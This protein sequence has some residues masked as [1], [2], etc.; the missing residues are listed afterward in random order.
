MLNENQV[1]KYIRPLLPIPTSVRKSG[2]I[3]EKIECILFD[4]YGTLF[5][6]GSG[7]IGLSKKQARHAK[8]LESLLQRFHIAKSPGL[9]L[10]DLHH[11]I[12]QKHA[13]LK[14]GG[15]DYPEVR[16]DTI[17][18]RILIDKDMETVQN[19]ALEFE[20]IIN[21][22]YPMPHV[23]ET[24]AKIGSQNIKMGIISNAQFY[25]PYLFKWLTGSNAHTLGFDPDLTLYS[26]TFNHAKPS[27]YL[28]QIAAEQLEKINIPAYKTLFVGN[29]MRN[30]I[31]P[32]KKTGFKTALFAGDRRSLR[33]RQDD[34]RCKHL[35]ADIIITDLIQLLEYA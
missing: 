29:D 8:A 33:M 21:P 25:T 12:E 4:I 32:A 5:V 13:E 14:N 10:N 31:Y 6:S 2:K 17:W 19:F 7:D 26:Y 28:F 9:I 1:K 24:L 18:K 22:V 27:E 30:D 3:A 35:K 20:L 11:A 34:P 23:K 15:I 16:I